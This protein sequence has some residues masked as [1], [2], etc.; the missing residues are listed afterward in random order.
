MMEDELL[1]LCV[2]CHIAIVVDTS[3]VVP[4]SAHDPPAARY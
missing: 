1:K 4:R 2:V 3:R